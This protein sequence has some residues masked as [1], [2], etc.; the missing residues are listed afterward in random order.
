MRPAET[1]DRFQEALV[2]PAVGV[3]QYPCRTAGHEHKALPPAQGLPPGISRQDVQKQQQHTSRPR[4]F[5]FPFHQNEDAPLVVLVQRDT[6]LCEIPQKI[7]A[8]HASQETPLPGSHPACLSLLHGGYLYHA[9]RVALFRHSLS[10]RVQRLCPA[11]V[12]QELEHEY[13]Y[14]N[15]PGPPCAHGDHPLFPLQRTI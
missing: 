12:E 4:Q 1:P 13:Q 8:Q 6:Q 2:F 15:K 3:P 5:L 10:L 11:A 7:R 14:Q 9:D